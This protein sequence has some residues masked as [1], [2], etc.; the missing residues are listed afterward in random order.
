MDSRR[1]WGVVFA[2]AIYLPWL[3]AA[4]GAEQVTHSRTY[5][6]PKFELGSGDVTDTYK[7]LEFPP[8]HIAMRNFYAEVVDEEGN[9][10]PLYDVYLH[11]WVVFKFFVKKGLKE[12]TSS[13]PKPI[14]S[15]DGVRTP[16]MMN[17][18][19]RMAFQDGADPKQS[20]K[21][22]TCQDDLSAQ[23][24][25]QGS[26]TRHTNAMI[27]APYG[28]VTGNTD[29]IPEG[30]EEA[31]YLNV[32]AIDTRG[33]VDA[34][35]CLEC[36]CE[37]YGV[38]ED[39]KGHT[40]NDGYKGG[41]FCCY[42]KTHCA[43]DENYAGVRKNYF[44]KYEVTWV[45]WDSSVVPV[46]SYS[47]DVTDGRTSLSQEPHCEIEYAVPECTKGTPCINQRHTV[48]AVPVGGDLIY[49][50]LHQHAGGLGGVIYDQDGV[51]CSSNP[52]YGKGMEAGDEA[53]YLVGMTSCYPVP[54]SIY[55]ESMKE[56]HFEAY[57][58]SEKAHTGVMS[59]FNVMV[60]DPMN[61]IEEIV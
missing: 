58:S 18:I 39:S 49:A 14:H 7:L 57:Y 2:L 9:S 27:P 34:T 29:E 54:G 11:H 16:S 25:G 50:V 10:V 40:L 12:L 13:V 28:L 36:L 46:R 53:G 59:I 41:L 56:L 17:H 47:F 20:Q 52:I 51:I 48:G 37:A 21:H 43:V 33:A 45:E 1:V 24:Y 55:L 35:S 3:S 32:H 5:W 30:Y 19:E 31:W 60:A 44:L 4:V 61:Y 22:G 8:G 23:Y 38:T 26:E 6:S 42:D 15:A